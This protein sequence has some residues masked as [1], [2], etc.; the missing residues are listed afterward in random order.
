M[1]IPSC[2]LAYHSGH[3]RPAKALKSMNCHP[4][5]QGRRGAPLFR[6]RTTRTT[7]T[8]AA[9]PCLSSRRAAKRTH[10]GPRPGL[11]PGA[12][13]PGGPG[14]AP[15]RGFVRDDNVRV[16]QVRVVRVVRG[17]SLSSAPG[18]FP[19]GKLRD[20]RTAPSHKDRLMDRTLSPGTPKD[21]GLDPEGLAAID[22][23]LQGLIDQR[24]LAGAV[25]LVA[26]HGKVVHTSAMGKKDLASGEP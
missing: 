22:A 25:T 11:D 6:P 18:T 4:A 15:L 7:P 12:G 2:G 19:R 16:G 23:Y 26:R 5:E 17:Q 21:V 20:M 14:S 9:H 1:K 10:P 13:A 3:A 8:E 24:E